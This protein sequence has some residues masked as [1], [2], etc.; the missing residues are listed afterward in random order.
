MPS[1]HLPLPADWTLALASLAGLALLTAALSASWKAILAAPWRVHL[2]FGAALLLG[3]LRLASFR[4]G[5]SP[6]VHLLGVTVA[7]L[8]LGP[9]FALLVASA[10]EIVWLL[11]AGVPWLEASADTALEV[12]LPVTIIWAL[13][14]LLLRHGP[15]NHFAFTLL[16]G[17]AGGAATMAAVC[18]VE[19]A[20]IRAQGGQAMSFEVV[21]LL[22]YAEGFVSGALL[23]VLAV[24]F[25]H[26]LKAYDDRHFEP[27][28]S[29]PP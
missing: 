22:S 16:G 2:L 3:A 13:F 6:E 24:Y 10:V 18:L 23:A 21:A 1:P 5:A 11:V 26:W 19:S 4:L 14:S 15:R 25:P 8:L 12:L 20:L 28:A 29:T 17:F 7:S 9:R 27:P